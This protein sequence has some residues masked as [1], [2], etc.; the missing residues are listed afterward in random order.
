MTPSRSLS[1]AYASGYLVA[2]NRHTNAA[3]RRNSRNRHLRVRQDVAGLLPTL[4]RL[5]D[6]PQNSLLHLDPVADPLRFGTR[7]DGYVIFAIGLR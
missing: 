3:C 7:C 5:P 1:L 2:V 4:R 6:E